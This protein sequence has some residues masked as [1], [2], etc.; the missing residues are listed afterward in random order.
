MT[1]KKSIEKEMNQL[2]AQGMPE[3][4]IQ[5]YLQLRH[6]ASADEPPMS[7]SDA[8]R[9][10]ARVGNVPGTYIDS[11]TEQQDAYS[12]MLELAELRKQQIEIAAREFGP[13]PIDPY[14]GNPNARVETEGQN[15]TVS[16]NGTVVYY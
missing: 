12:K 3:E 6:S 9:I 16:P 2:R 5:Q 10:T 1:D 7:K 14:M 15:V 4:M 13:Q 8:V 11:Y